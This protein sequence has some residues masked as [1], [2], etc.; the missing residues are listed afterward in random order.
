MQ[1]GGIFQA[2]Q[3]N[4]EFFINSGVQY[5]KK[6]ANPMNPEEESIGDIKI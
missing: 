4:I 5:L 6:S 2:P 3:R 1:P